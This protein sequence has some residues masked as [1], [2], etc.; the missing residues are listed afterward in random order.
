MKLLEKL[1]QYLGAFSEGDL[2]IKYRLS[3]KIKGL[4]V[5]LNDKN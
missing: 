4:E 5:V 1:F 3:D 2:K